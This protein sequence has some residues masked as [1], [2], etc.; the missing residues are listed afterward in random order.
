MK[1]KDTNLGYNLK[2]ESYENF[3]GWMHFQNRK[4]TQRLRKKENKQTNSGSQ[5]GNMRARIIQEVGPN[6]YTQIHWK[7][8][9]SKSLHPAEGT[10]VNNAHWSICEK[11][12]IRT[13]ISVSTTESP[14]CTPQNIQSSKSIIQLYNYTMIQL[15]K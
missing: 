6:I 5:R 14:G 3:I 7:S 2:A 13:V 1:E 12:Q 10:L 9:T 11:S 4:Q 15:Y 8:I